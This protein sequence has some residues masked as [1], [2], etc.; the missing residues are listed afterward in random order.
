MPKCI[1][2]NSKK[3]IGNEPTPKGLGYC[4]SGY[5]VGKCKYGKDGNL[6][7]IIQTTT[8]KKWKKI[9]FNLDNLDDK[10]YRNVYFPVYKKIENNDSC[11]EN[12]LENK[13]GGKIPFFIEGEEWPTNN[14]YKMTFF[15][16][17]SDP[18]E[19]TE[20]RFLYRLFLPIND[21]DNYLL[22]NCFISKIELNKEN[23]SKQVILSIDDSKEE[24]SE[25]VKEKPIFYEPYEIISW[26]KSKE[27]I[28]FDEILNLFQINN[29]DEVDESDKI[30]ENMFHEKYYDDYFEHPN[31]PSIDIKIGGTSQFC[32]YVSDLD[33]HQNF[34]Q[35]SKCRELPYE[36]GDSG[37]GHIF[38]SKDSDIYYLYHDQ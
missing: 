25:H 8:C 24:I 31:F 6:Y 38:K 18:R 29:N 15:C 28:S 14:G 1:N 2:D 36:W 9:N 30:D 7:T 22:E 12:G 32:Q 17:F 33:K 34:F 16:Q 20:N 23:L 5:K 11:V 35:I 10:Y 19:E 21:K 27:L 4:A 13:V 26:N 3:F 37:I